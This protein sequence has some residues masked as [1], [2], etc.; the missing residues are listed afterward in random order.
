[1]EKKENL[2]MGCMVPLENIHEPCPNCLYRSGTPNPTGTLPIG[3]VLGEHYL[4]G[5]VLWQT[6]L[7]TAYMGLDTTKGR[8]VW[9][10]EFLP[11]SL[12]HR[13]SEEA[14]ILVEE[15][16]MAR[17]KTLLSDIADRWK[18]LAKIENR[19]LPRIRD[20]VTENGT[21]YSV[22]SAIS[23]TVTLEQY[24]MGKKPLTWPS[25]KALLMPLFSLVSNLHNKGLVHGGISP[26]TVLV[27]NKG[28]AYHVGFALPELRTDGSGIQ[29]QL[30]PGYSA[31]EQY[32]KSQ[33][34]GEWTDIYALGALLYRAF[35]G[36][37]PM[38]APHREKEKSD[39]SIGN[40][41]RKD[42][43]VSVSVAVERA[44][45]LSK[46]ARFASVD[47]FT[48]ALLEEAGSNTAVFHAEQPKA[49]ATKYKS[50]WKEPKNVLAGALAASI[51]LNL[52]LIAAL[53]TA[54]AKHPVPVEETSAEE[55]APIMLFDF[56]GMIIS[57]AQAR[58]VAFLPDIILRQEMQ[59]S[60]TIPKDVVISQSIDAGLPL[61]DDM[62]VT[63][64]VSK[65]TAYVD[66]PYLVGASE[67]YARKVL[68]EAGFSFEVQYNT[69]PETPGIVGTV[70]DSSK[71]MGE[72]IS[73]EYLSEEKITITVKKEPED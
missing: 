58:Q 60:E 27:D 7:T 72:R 50:F 28:R 14:S 49:P 15:K 6:S 2:C 42:I 23:N 46:K 32:S 25:A 69:D 70:I 39:S 19:C 20:L 51:V 10:E 33:W 63:L 9:L 12:S 31:P 16:D 57:E 65:G 54:S 45:E 48:A 17:F 73:K 11:Q 67:L 41:F 24:F 59:Y 36:Y 61:P 64:I 40:S 4:V 38:E 68:S 56:T 35:S 52:F 71:G 1:M 3:T 29:P 5:R 47:A 55:Q 44:M 66:V 26:K 8:R 62:V 53:G 21:I 34:Q 37:D 22:T 18:R 43:P 30:F 13:K